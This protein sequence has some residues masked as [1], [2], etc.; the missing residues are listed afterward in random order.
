MNAVCER[1]F[2]VDPSVVP[3]YTQQQV[4]QLVGS[5]FQSEVVGF[6][7]NSPRGA[8]LSFGLLSPVEVDG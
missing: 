4:P 8:E 3:A 5:Y 7:L 1:R 2:D 6:T